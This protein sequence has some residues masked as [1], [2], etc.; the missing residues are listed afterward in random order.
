[1]CFVKSPSL[2]HP[3]NPSPLLSRVIIYNHFLVAARSS[4]YVSR[5]PFPC[6]GAF[7]AV[8]EW[9]NF[10]NPPRKVLS[11]KNKHELPFGG[12]AAARPAPR[13]CEP[14]GR[15]EVL[16]RSV[17]PTC[18]AVPIINKSALHTHTHT[19][20]TMLWE[21][22]EKREVSTIS[23][24]TFLLPTCWSIAPLGVLYVS[25]FLWN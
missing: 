14:F 17:L 5:S 7:C 3:V 13:C 20:Q 9:S 4:V 1:M 2:L 18:Q 8:L 11:V 16:P 6:C 25:L 10:H 15:C 21:G 22:R 24:T 23:R 12:V 19:R